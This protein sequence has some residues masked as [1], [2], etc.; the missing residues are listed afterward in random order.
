[1][2]MA[3]SKIKSFITT[4][5]RFNGVPN[6]NGY[7]ATDLPLD[8]YVPIGV[9]NPTRDGWQYEFVSYRSM[10]N[11]NWTMRIVSS[12]TPTGTFE[13]RIIAIRLGGG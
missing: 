6:S 9:K 5:Y 4:E 11:T 10:D 12:N 1:M 8:G 7:L 13:G 2:N 3:T